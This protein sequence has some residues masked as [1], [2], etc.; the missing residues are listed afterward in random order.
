MLYATLLN[1]VGCHRTSAVPISRQFDFLVQISIQ[2]LLFSADHQLQ[3]DMS[4]LAGPDPEFEML[5]LLH[6][7][8]N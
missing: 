5:T 3:I 7:I 2:F 8:D 1:L 4:L 6:Q